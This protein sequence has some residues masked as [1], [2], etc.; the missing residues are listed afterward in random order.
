MGHERN[1][2]QIWFRFTFSMRLVL[3]RDSLTNLELTFSCQYK[4]KSPLLLEHIA[5]EQWCWRCG[6]VDLL[7]LHMYSNHLSPVY[8][9][10]FIKPGLASPI[11]NKPMLTFNGSFFFFKWSQTNHFIHRGKHQAYELYFLV[12]KCFSF[13]KFEVFVHF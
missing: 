4:T 1:K 7:G 5:R 9:T 8:N 6:Q 2:V 11:F 13:L 10:I 12:P 3:G